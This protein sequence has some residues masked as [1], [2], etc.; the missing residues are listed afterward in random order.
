[1]PTA[2]KIKLIA[3]D[4]DGTLLNSRAEV[5]RE[6][7]EAIG[8]AAA[9]GAEIMIVTGRRFD[10]ARPVVEELPCELHLIVNNG[11]LIKSK[12]GE[13]H[14]RQLLPEATALRVLEA[15][16]EFREHAAVQFDRPREMQIV[17]E[18]ADWDHPIRGRYLRKNREY[19]G[20]IAPLTA[21]LNGEDPIQVMLTG[22]CAEMR[23]AMELLAA[24]PFAGEFTLALTEYPAR[25]FSILDVLRVGVTKGTALAEWIGRRGVRR[26]E[27]MAIGDNWNDREMLELAGVPVVMGNSAPEMQ[28]LGWTVTGTADEHGV[29]QAIRR[30]ALGAERAR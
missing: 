20:E 25:D 30:Y 11:A 6:N 15:A 14:Y 22:T 5:S 19:I 1:V 23:A 16:A 12:S 2:E 13:T 7:A 4:I 9:R 8:A 17:M 27:V 24:L 21:C 10:F 3:L 28:R 26:E 29:A 18:R